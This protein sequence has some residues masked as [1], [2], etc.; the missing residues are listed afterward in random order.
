MHA[1]SCPSQYWNSSLERVLVTSTVSQP[2]SELLSYSLLLRFR[3][4]LS[5]SAIR[6]T[7]DYVL[8]GVKG[9]PCHGSGRVCD[10]SLVGTI[11]LSYACKTT[12][13]FTTSSGELP[14][15]ADRHPRQ[16]H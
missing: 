6:R 1:K 14:S 2:V 9:L 5:S 8:R 7:M 16:I 3:P 11:K 10:H 12:V 4:H 15:D 13:S